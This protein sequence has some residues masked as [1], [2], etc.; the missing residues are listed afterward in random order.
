MQHHSFGNLM[1]WGTVLNQIWQLENEGKLDQ[2]Q[3][4]LVHILRFQGNWRLREE[5][6]MRI[7]AIEQPSEA[8]V[9]QVLNLIADGNLYYEARI[10]ACRAMG[11]LLKKTGHQFAPETQNAIT[12]TVEKLL[13]IPEPPIFTEALSKLYLIV[14]ERFDLS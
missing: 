7:G 10:L 6:L 2:H 1:D 13:P 3:A 8:L 14:R 9:Q 11:K 12:Q 4:G 5:T